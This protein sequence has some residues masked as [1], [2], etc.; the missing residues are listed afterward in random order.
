M[1]APQTKKRGPEDGGEDAAADDLEAHEGGSR[2]EDGRVEAQEVAAAVHASSG[3][4]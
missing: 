1:S 3:H 4:A 2:E